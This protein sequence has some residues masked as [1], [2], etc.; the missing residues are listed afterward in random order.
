MWDAAEIANRGLCLLESMR[1]DASKATNIKL[2]EKPVSAVDPLTPVYPEYNAE[3]PECGPGSGSSGSSS[4]PSGSPNDYCTSPILAA[5]TNNTEGVRL[6]GTEQR[7]FFMYCYDGSNVYRYAGTF[8]TDFNP[9]TP[10]VPYA[11]Y[12]TRNYT[13]GAIPVLGDTREIIITNTNGTMDIE[14]MF[15]RYLDLPNVVK[16][17]YKITAPGPL[18]KF[19]TLTHVGH[20]ACKN[21]VIENKIFTLQIEGSL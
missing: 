3:F 5:E 8:A 10:A 18:S 19:C 6:F 7:K 15:Y 11:S 1:R 2:P 17:H 12:N 20:P 13:C 4:S 16:A 9:N 14:L 21:P